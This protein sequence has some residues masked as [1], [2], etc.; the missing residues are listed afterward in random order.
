MKKDSNS[1]GKLKDTPDALNEELLSTW[2]TFTSAV[3]SERIVKDFTFREIFIMHILSHHE[4]GTDIKNGADLE[5]GNDVR[6]DACPLASSGAPESTTISDTVRKKVSG[7]VTATDIVNKTG[8]LKPQVNKIL[9]ALES[10]GLILRRRSAADK[11][12]VFI[13]LTP[14]GY[15]Q[16]LKEHKDILSL[17][18]TVTYE[19]GERH[20]HELIVGLDSVSKIMNRLISGRNSGN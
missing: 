12:Y 5:T 10:R 19:L 9:E 7:G 2:L 16:Y 17:L 11:R 20:T 15:S 8:M 14:L 1:T 3:R 18:S 13:S 6:S 4:A